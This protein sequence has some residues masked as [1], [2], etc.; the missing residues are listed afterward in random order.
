MILAVIGYAALTGFERV[1]LGVMIFAVA[2]GLLAE[3]LEWWLGMRFAQRYGGSK[4]A[5]W[6]ALLGG[7]AG[8]IVGIPLPLVGS[9]VGAFLG[10]FAG[11][12]LFEWTVGRRWDPSMRAGWGAVVGK[13]LGT[14]AK[15]GA[16]LAVAIA[17]TVAAV[18]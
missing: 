10:A 5:G 15:V 1:G 12:A 9:V 4:R 7:I 14:A 2:L 3:A 16:A 11:A 8:G 13:A 18:R 17:T 6:G